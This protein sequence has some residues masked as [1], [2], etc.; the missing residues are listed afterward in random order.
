[1]ISLLKL[2]MK[3]LV[4][5][6]IDGRKDAHLDICK[7]DNVQYAHPAGFD[8]VHLVHNAMPEINLGEVNCETSFLK[9]KLNAPFMISAM[10]G[11]TQ[12]GL[13]VNKK[14]A[15]FAGEKKVALGLGSGRPMLESKEKAKF[16]QVRDEAGADA[17]IIANIG[18]VQLK[19]YSAEQIEE[20]V[21][22]VD[23]DALAVHLNA[24]QE[25][26]QPEG[27]TEFSGV[28]SQ[29]RK[30]CNEVD[31]PVIAKETGAGINASVAKDLFSAGVEFVE[32]SGKGGTSWSKVEYERGGK[33]GGFEEWGY[34]TVPALCE[35][36][37]I[38]KCICSG[39]VKSGVDVAK[40]ISLGAE[41][42]GAAAPFLKTEELGMEIDNW[43][44]QVKTSMFLC[45]AKNL[46]E[47]RQAPVLVTGGSADVMRLRGIDPCLYAQREIGKSEKKDEP[48]HYM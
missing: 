34:P 14:L 4:M 39:G 30:L 32:V 23:A 9:K 12:R 17:V 7:N 24:L 38:G 48:N 5:E 29:I 43:I 33:L 31:V 44:A 19:E 18:A 41:L 36:A 15:S 26:I 28:Y 6:G 25:A 16:Y 20:M 47:L 2:R 42:A 40:A 11:G 46:E 37:R 3:V 1:M 22:A 21:L 10:T 13:E 35:C 45:G 8:D 27:Q